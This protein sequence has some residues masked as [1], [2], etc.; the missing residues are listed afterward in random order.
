MAQISGNE[1]PLKTH[2]NANFIQTQYPNKLVFN[3]ERYFL[4]Y[5]TYEGIEIHSTYDFLTYENT[6]FAND[7]VY[8]NPKLFIS[9]N[10]HPWVLTQNYNNKSQLFYSY[11][12][13]YTNAWITPVQL[14]VLPS[15][16]QIKDYS[17]LYDTSTNTHVIV[18]HA[19]SFQLYHTVSSISG[20]Q[21][22]QQ[23][24]TLPTSTSCK[25]ANVCRAGNDV[26]HFVVYAVV[27]GVGKLYY[28]SGVR[29]SWGTWDAITSSA[30]NTTDFD[31]IWHDN[32]VYIGHGTTAGLELITGTRGNWTTQK[33]DDTKKCED[34]SLCSDGT[35]VHIGYCDS[36]DWAS[37]SKTYVKYVKTVSGTL[38]TP[39]SFVNGN[40]FAHPNVYINTKL[41]VATIL[42]TTLD[43]KETYVMNSCFTTKITNHTVKIEVLEYQRDI[44]AEADTTSLYIISQ[45]HGLESGDF[46]INTTERSQSFYF[47][48]RCSRPVFVR[49]H[50]VLDLPYPIVD[51]VAG[52]TIKLFKFV[53]RTSKLVAKTLSFKKSAQGRD[54]LSFSFIVDIDSNNNLPYDL[55]TGMYIRLSINN[56]RQ[57]TGI[58]KEVNYVKLNSQKMR[59]DV[60]IMNLNE[61][62][63]TITT[64]FTLGFDQ[65]CEDMI[66]FYLQE[67]NEAGIRRGY[68]ETGSKIGAKWGNEKMTLAELMDACASV[69]GYQWH[70]DRNCRLHFYE[71]LPVQTICPVMLLTKK[72]TARYDVFHDFRNISIKK[73]LDNYYNTVMIDGGTDVR[74]WGIYVRRANMTNILAN[75][76]ICCGNSEYGNII[77]ET[78]IVNTNLYTAQSGT[79]GNTIVINNHGLVVGDTVVNITRDKSSAVIEIVNANTFRVFNDFTHYSGDKIRLCPQINAMAKTELRR[80]G[81]KNI[82]LSFETFTPIFEPQMALYVEADEYGI[83]EKWFMI[84]DVT[85]TDVGNGYLKSVITAIQ[86]DIND[87]STLKNPDFLN[88]FGGF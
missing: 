23:V 63:S 19:T 52:D 13:E 2:S 80:S 12:E 51:Q 69:S 83:S 32:K 15:S 37:Q 86:R 11:H 60:S 74:G 54:N 39:I 85:I 7:I 21:S 43:N 53:D 72:D 26:M 49:R 34:V 10:N 33:V 30:S 41:D 38:Q 1:I 6:N 88:F 3:S 82:E 16:A 81:D 14:P 22:F 57:L 36:T 42:M 46:I 17:L 31:I 47:V 45:N 73:S 18:Q 68:I 44:T 76:N 20:W 29:G 84:T 50:D 9:W 5:N 56:F 35:D 8:N 28:N 27:S 55:T 58:V 40:Q 78:S 75:H 66:L 79:S 48:D 59:L 70:V 24:G 67:M 4:G 65:D 77:R 25:M 64:R 87:F 62:L 61:R 71:E